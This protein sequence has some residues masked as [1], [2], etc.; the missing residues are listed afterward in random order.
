MEKLKILIVEDEALVAYQLRMSLH[1]AGYQVCRPVVSGEEAITSAKE[2]KPEV[3][4]VDIRL[5]G[6]MDG[7]E[8][9]R[10]ISMFSTARIIFTTGY[11]DLQLKERAL[12]LKPAAYLNKPIGWREIEAVIQSF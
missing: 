3:I 2:E 12:A 11:Q 8:A 1:R 9:A 10:Q 7:I 4:I 5:I 6:D